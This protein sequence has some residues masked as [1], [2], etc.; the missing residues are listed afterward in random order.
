MIKPAIM[1]GGSGTR[2]WSLSRNGHTKKRN[3]S[4]SLFSF[5]VPTCSGL[6]G[7]SL[8]RLEV[9]NVFQITPSRLRN[10]MLLP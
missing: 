1:A 3:F 7:G 8:L 2:L 5:S 6:V 4:G 9:Y 10:V